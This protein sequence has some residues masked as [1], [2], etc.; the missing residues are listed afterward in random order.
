MGGDMPTQLS[1]AP[2]DP[3]YLRFLEGLRTVAGDPIGKD[4]WYEY[5]RKEWVLEDLG[6][7]DT[8]PET[9][10]SMDFPRFN[11]QDM[12]FDTAPHA[13]TVYESG[14]PDLFQRV[15]KAHASLVQRYPHATLVWS[16]WG[17]G[18][19]RSAYKRVDGSPNIDETDDKTGVPADCVRRIN[20]VGEYR[21]RGLITND[22]AQK[23]VAAIV[24][25]CT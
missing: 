8:P 15:Q 13:R 16:P 18:D 25:E 21:R 4:R 20:E 11:I 1:T 24:A 5:S 23:L 3:A 17:D 6:L 9:A 12:K 10:L 22:Q 14:V 7:A 2:T 19:W